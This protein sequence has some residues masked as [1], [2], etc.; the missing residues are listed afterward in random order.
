MNSRWGV[1]PGRPKRAITPLCD[2]PFNRA[3][4]NISWI[5]STVAGAV[6]VA[7]DFPEWNRPG[8]INYGPTR[9]FKDAVLEALEV[10]NHG[11]ENKKSEEF[12]RENLMLS[13]VNQKR[14]LIAEI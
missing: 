8:I 14:I 6:C 4:S 3:K 1:F 11:F 9:P 13:T 10:A 5:E 2:T 7:P 12:I